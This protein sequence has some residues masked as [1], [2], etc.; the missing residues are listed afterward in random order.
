MNDNQRKPV[1]LFMFEEGP[2]EK[3][4]SLRERLLLTTPKRRRKRRNKAIQ[5]SLIDL[6]KELEMSEG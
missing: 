1:Q 2:V 5:L 4:M 6:L 3:P